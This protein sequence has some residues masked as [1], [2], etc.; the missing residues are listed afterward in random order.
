MGLR[1]WI[2]W[3]GADIGYGLFSKIL[4]PRA[5][6][7]AFVVEQNEIL[8]VDT[9]EYLML[10]GGGLEYGET[11]D[12]AAERETLE[13]TGYRVEVKQKLCER[14]NSVGG[15]EV[16]YDAEILESEQL[17][18]GTWEGKPVWIGLDEIEDRTWRHNRDVKAVLDAKQ[19]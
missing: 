15:V 2:A 5:S 18:E 12:E 13:E 16:V 3:K 11:F 8:A 14:I 6:A 17:N 4:W 9:G 7:V 19:S 1:S 10:P